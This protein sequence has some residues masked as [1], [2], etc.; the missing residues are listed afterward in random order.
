L[1]YRA[2]SEAPASIEALMPIAFEDENA[3]RWTVVPQPTPRPG[4]PGHTTLV[5]TSERGERRTCD[6][7]L[8]ER[9]TWDEVDQRVWCALLRHAELMPVRAKPIV[10]M[11]SK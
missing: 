3:V 10:K 4:E 7:C 8:P 1:S 9:G 2:P 5:F 11:P 6:G